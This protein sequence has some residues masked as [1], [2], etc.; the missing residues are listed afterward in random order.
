[1][2][3][4]VSAW[5]QGKSEGDEESKTEGDA[6]ASVGNTL[7]DG[8]AP[9]SADEIRRK[10]L[11]KLQ[12]AQDA[13]SANPS[14]PNPKD[15]VIMT[16]QES[17]SDK[18]QRVEAVEPPKEVKKKQKKL[19]TQPEVY[20]ND[21]LQ[22]VLRVTLTPANSSSELL[23]LPQFATQSEELLLSTAN[24][25]EVLY[26]R[27][28]MSPAELPG[29]SQHPLAALT[30]L[31]QVFYRC[32]DEMQKLQSSFVRLSAEQK[33]EV[34]QCLTSIR[35]MCIN[36]SATALTDP[37]I[38][39]FEA[40]TINADALE[41]TVRLQGNA[42]TPEFV[43]G[44]V[45]QLEASD[46]TLAVF[47]PIFQK[48]L[49]ELFL[50]NPPS[51]MSNFYNNMYV[52]TVLC[53]NKA[54]ATAFTQIPGFLLT[55]GLPMTG[56]RLQDATA[57]G[58]LL[59]FSCGQDP[60]ITQ[61]FT[62]ITKRTKN[63]VDNSILTIR[64]KLDSVQTTV[65]DIV[66]LLLKAGGTAREQVLAWLEQAMQV[67]AERAK[68]NPDVNITATNGM[69][70]NLTMV[71][72]KLCGPFLAAKSKKAQL[73]KA[74]YLTKQNPL[75]PFDET[76]L[77]GAGSENAVAQ[78]DDRQ[79]L[80]PADFN[81]ISR[82]YFITARAMHL[83]PVGIMGQYM[84][85]LRQLSYYQNRMNAPNADP[86]LR[87]H[88]DQMAAAKMIMDAEL[89]HPDFLHEMIR[90]SLLTC[91][92]VNSICTGS[93]A[94]DESVSL[95]LPLPA[96]DTKANAVLKYIPEHLVDDLCTALKFV[97]RL[98]LKA[99]NA[100]ELNELLK[101]VIIFLSSPGYVHSPHLR[102]KMSEVLFHIFLPS[103]ESE[104]R[105]TA[106]TAFGVE[107]LMTNPL[108]QRHLAPCLLGLYG[109]VEHTGFYE[110][111]EHRYNI[112]CL[113]K[114]LWKLDGHKPAF[115]LIAEDRDNFVKFAHGLMNH[116]NSLV[117]DALIALPE[118]KV[119]QEEMQDVAR[120]MALDE[121][122]RE[123]KQS[124]LSDK[125][126]T[127]TSSLQLAN[128]TIHMMSYLT[129]EIQEPFVKMPELE[130]RLVSMLNSVL[131]KLAGPRGVE[132]KVNN[133][134]Q[135]KFRPK[136]MLKEIVETLLHFAHY[137]SFLEAVA[138]NGYY[139]GQVFRKC[140]HIV[141]RTQLLVPNDVQKFE[142]FVLD[143]E[144]AA[145]GAANL[146]E[147]LGD[148]PEEFLDPLVF[149][150]MKDPV[151]LPSGY[152]MDRSCITQHLMNDQSDPFTRVPL[153]MEQLQPNTDLKT[154]IEQWIQEQQQKQK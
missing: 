154:K 73:I 106:G 19:S 32:R 70:V 136:T 132:L 77:I 143:V 7:S 117:T 64:N 47:A 53:R 137:P 34:Q 27:V 109:D 153:T 13:I 93:T 115:L 128:E 74:E 60:A 150:L 111:L 124:L 48:L 140:A 94:Y 90:M 67:N 76:R 43:D 129:S 78:Q 26:S 17:P 149:T 59:R 89:L 61:M 66:T 82:C 24:A 11:Q 69:F 119:L 114:Y 2:S 85:L 58:L 123:Q 122:V 28:I 30:Y 1:M 113:L 65:S 127:V 108:A 54:L 112:A 103:E 37:E 101:M 6:F 23:L 62:N 42:Q 50:I 45:A 31:E 97:A 96:P 105:E 8:A 142:T 125:E 16:N 21:M 20:V 87:A 121:T 29:G 92:V 9:A 38:F 139:D 56:R 95:Q 116:I 83:G 102:A 130:D 134:E 25:S 91:A 33:Q 84:R 35:E 14:P 118:V 98:Q 3:G 5:L 12:E 72:L 44:V 100:F 75:F 110:K 148:I 46:A 120:W 152:T 141:A 51:L 18:K 147:M 107:L 104:E 40:G 131:V 36:Y 145:E 57:L 22:R 39:P 55:P 135:Y 151:L 79:P 71:L 52:L 68:E 146:E 126:R 41:K 15:D 138:A 99:L 133:P 49:S 81:F 10:R 63:D 80:N 86:R 88:F 144:K 4:W